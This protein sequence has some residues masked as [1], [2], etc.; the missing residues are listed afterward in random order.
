MLSCLMLM[1]LQPQNGSYSSGDY[2]YI[3][4]KHFIYSS[5]NYI[6]IVLIAKI[7]LTETQHKEAHAPNNTYTYT[8]MSVYIYVYMYTL[9]KN[10]YTH[11]SVSIHMYE[12]L[13][14]FPVV[15]V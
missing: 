1:G 5:D 15:M 13:I 7:C 10:K 12:T 6:Y 8:R 4:L 14:E 11:V 3:V 9:K 2:I